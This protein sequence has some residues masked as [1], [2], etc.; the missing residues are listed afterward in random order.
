MNTIL[1]PID[2]HSER[3]A[4]RNLH[5]ILYF[6]KLRLNIDRFN[7]Y[8]SDNNF[9]RSYTKE[10][11]SQ[12]FAAAT[13]KLV[14]QLEEILKLKKS[15]ANSVN[16]LTA[17]KL[18]ELLIEF[19]GLD[20]DIPEGYPFKIKDDMKSEKNY[21]I[22][23]KVMLV[24]DKSG[25]KITVI[26][27]N[28]NLRSETELG[29]IETSASGLFTISYEPVF[30]KSEFKTADIFFR[31][32]DGEK[33]LRD[34]TVLKVTSTGKNVLPDGILFNATASV[35]VEIKLFEQSAPKVLSE[36]EDIG[37]L[38]IPL[39]EDTAIVA[40]NENDEYRDFS[41]LSRETELD[42]NKIIR[43][44]LSYRLLAQSGID[45]EFW[46]AL[47]SGSFYQDVTKSLTDQNLDTN[48]PKT[49][50]ALFTV[51]LTSV[52]ETVKQAFEAT[53]IS[54]ELESR[55][56]KWVKQFSGFI[57]KRIVNMKRE[58]H[59]P[60]VKSLM[61]SAGLTKEK[62][63]KFLSI[64]LNH[65]GFDEAF[66]KQVEK[67]KG[68][69]ENET[70]KL[71][72]AHS[73][74]KLEGNNERLVSLAAALPR[75]TSM[76]ELALKHNTDSLSKLLT[77]E[78]LPDD[79]EGKT[80]KSKIK[81]YASTIQRQLFATE[82]S[83]V[84]QRMATNKELP[85]KDDQISKG[86]ADFFDNQSEFN[87][88]TT[89]IYNAIKSENAFKGIAEKHREEVVSHLKT[90][91]RV[92][93]ISPANETVV[94][95]MKANISTSHRVTEMSESSFMTAF[96]KKMGEGVA[97]QVYTNA[98]NLKLRNE[99]ALISMKEHVEG[100]GISLIDGNGTMD[101]RKVAFDT[102]AAEN[103]I[104]LNWETLFGNVDLCECG[105]CTSVYSPAAYFV[106]LLQYLRN[107]DLD[108][109]ATGVQAIKPDPKDISDTVL[110]KLFRRRPDLGCLE[111]TC[112][113]T[114]TI[115]PY[116]DLVNEVMESFIVHLAG[117][118]KSKLNPKQATIDAWNVE[119]E[120]T[121]ELLAQPQ[122]IN[123][124]AYLELKKAVYPFTL[125]Y[126]RPVDMIRIFLRYLDTS[127]YELMKTFRA[128]EQNVISKD[129][130]PED[131]KLPV[132]PSPD[133]DE[134]KI[135][136]FNK[137]LSDRA[138]D[139]EFLS[140]TQ[141]EYIILTKEAYLTKDYFNL[142]SPGITEGQYKAQIGVKDVPEYYG[143]TGSNGKS[144]MLSTDETLQ[145]GLTFVK[146][147]FL[148][149]TGL[150]YID[151]VELLKTEALN[152]MYPKG[153]AML[154]LESIPFSYRFLQGLED[155]TSLDPPIR[156]KKLIDALENPQNYIL[157]YDEMNDFNPCKPQ[158]RTRPAFKSANI[159]QWVFCYFERI[160]KMI[161][162]ENN[163]PD[164]DCVEGQFFR[165]DGSD[166][167][168][169]V[170][171]EGQ[172]FLT[173]DCDLVLKR[174]DFQ[175]TVGHID[176][177]SGF[178]SLKD[179]NGDPVK[180]SVLT[181][182][183]VIFKGNNGEIGVIT[184]ERLINRRT[185][186]P[187]SC[188]QQ[189]TDTCDLNLVR[190]KHLDGT[191]LSVN[192]YDKM[193]R[194]IRL[195]R[196]M[197]WSIDETDKSLVALTADKTTYT[198]G[199][200]DACDPE[201]DPNGFAE[202]TP[203]FIHQLV[204]I[205]KLLDSTGLELIKLLAFWTTISTV[206]EKSLYK[207]LF[208]THN[209]LAIDDIFKADTNGNFLSGTQKIVDHIPV[210]MAAFHLKYE[211]IDALVSA[212]DLLTIQSVSMLYRN[213]VLAKLLH[214]KTADIK[215]IIALF[216]ADPFQ[217]ADKALEFFEKWDKMESSGFTFT[218]L[219]YLINDSDNLL[220]PIKPS[221]NTIIRLAKTI[222]D[223][224]I[225]IDNAHPDLAL[226]D[227]LTIKL[228]KGLTGTERK[229]FLK[230]IATEELVRSKVSL[231]FDQ[232]S[233]ESVMGLLQ[234]T[235]VYSAAVPIP[236][237]PIKT[238]DEFNK[239][240]PNT[241]AAEKKATAFLLKK[242]KYDFTN[243]NVQV[244]G[245]LT[246]KEQ[247]ICKSL[248]PNPGWEAAFDIIRDQAVYIFDDLLA[249]IFVKDIA[250]ATAILLDGDVKDPN[251]ADKDTAPAKREYFL[252]KFLPYL[253][254]KLTE[255][256]LIDTLSG[257]TGLDSSA[258]DILMRDILEGISTKKIMEIFKDAKMPPTS[259]KGWKGYLIP[260]AEESYELAVNEKTTAP[261]FSLQIDGVIKVDENTVPFFSSGP[262]KLKAGQFYLFEVA[263]LTSDLID[264]SWRT[265]ISAKSSLPQQ[266]L[267]PMSAIDVVEEG[268]IKLF[269]AA[270][271][272]NNFS[273]TADEISWLQNHTLDFDKLDFNTLILQHMLRL[274][275]YM[276][277]RDWLP[278]SDIT[279][280]DFFAWT[281]TAA[282]STIPSEKIGLLTGR[283]KEDIDVLIDPLHF[284]IIT[285]KDFSS[286]INLVKLLDA[287]FVYDKID[288]KLDL[289]FEWAKPVSQFNVC[290]LI[291]ETI[292]KSIQARYKQDD[293]EHIVKPLNDQLREHQKQALI[294]YLL[295]QTDLIVWGVVD[296]D[297]LFEFFLI[298]VQMDACMQTSRLKQAISSVQLFVQ[299]CFLGE[300]AIRGI[301]NK[302][303]DRDRWRWMQRNPL[304]V[305][306]KKIYIWPENWTLTSLRDDK[307]AFFKGLESDLLQ[308]D[309]N[310]QNVIDACKT[311]LYKVDEV[312]NMEVIGLH[313]EM[314]VDVNGKETK[315]PL[316]LHV[317]ARTRNAPYFF[318]YRYFHM[319]EANWYAWEKIQ[320]DIPSYD[321]D[322]VALTIQVNLAYFSKDSHMVTF[323]GLINYYPPEFN[324]FKSA[325]GVDPSINLTNLSKDENDKYIFWDVEFPIDEMNGMAVGRITEIEIYGDSFKGT[326]EGK[327]IRKDNTNGC[328][329]VPTVWHGRLL[330]FFPQIMKKTKPADVK[331]VS[332]TKNGA[333]NTEVPVLKPIEYYDIK[334]CWT[335]YRNR[336]W[337][338]KQMSKESLPTH[339]IDGLKQIEYFKFF[340]IV[341]GTGIF[342]IVDD[343]LDLDAGYHGAFT[344]D[345]NT[346]KLGGGGDIDNM[347]INYFN[348]IEPF[349][350]EVGSKIFSWQISDSKRANTSI[351][352][353]NT[354]AKEMVRGVAPASNFYHPYTHDYLSK[355]NLGQID[356]LFDYNLSIPDK[357]D[358][359]GANGVKNYHELKRPYSL[360]NWEL[361][362]HIPVSI[363]RE[364][365]AT[366]QFE[367]AM[368]YYHYVFDPTAKGTDP[369]RFWQFLPFKEVNTD[370]FLVNFFNGLQPNAPVKEINEWRSNPFQPHLIARSRPSTYMKWVVMEYIDNLIA[371][372]DYLFKQDTI[373][374][375]NYATQLYILAAHI[376][377]SFQTIPK[378]GKIKPETY[379]SLLDKWDAFG[380]AMVELELVAP[381][382][383]QISLPVAMVGSN[384]KLATANIFGFA[385]SLYFCIPNNPKLKAYRDT[386]A[387]RLYKIRHCE[388]IEGVFRMLPLWDPPIDPALLVAATAQG[389]SLDSVLN[390]LNTPI[391]NYRF[392]YL[393]QKAID[394]CNEVKSLGNSLLSVLEK[395]DGEALAVMRA[396]HET[397][398]HN[399]VMEVKK[400]QVEEA[401]AALEGLEQNRRTTEYK[402][403]HYLQ[404]IG[405]DV[406][407]VPSEDGSFS[408]ISNQLPTPI[409]EG[410][411][412]LIKEEK[413]EMD[414]AAQA[415]GWQIGSL[416]MDALSSLMHLLPDTTLSIMP[417]GIGIQF[418]HGG[419]NLG[420]AASGMA[421]VLQ[422]ISSIYSY[423]STS[424]QRKAGFRR[425]LQDRILQANLAG[426]ECKQIDKQILS[427]RIRINISNQE[428]TNQQ[429]MIDNT[430]EVEEFL[431]SKYTN[432]ELY[433]WMEGQVKT[434]YR[435][436]YNL[437]YDL[438]KKAELVFRFDRGLASSNF[439]QYGYWDVS[440][441]G[442]LAGEKLF[443]G[444]KQ[445][446]AAYH[447]NRG[448]DF[449]VT[450]HISLQQLNPLAL[451]ELRENGK[452]EFEI[453]EVLFDMDFSGHYMRR[454]KSVA[455]SI[456]CI[457]GPYTS[458]NATLR[459]QEHNYR[460]SP[461]ATNAKDYP[462]KTDENDDRFTT[463]HI[464]IASIATSSGQND[465]GVFELNF[466]DERYM[467]FEGAGVISKWRL[468]LQDKFRQFKYETISDIIIIIRYTSKDGGDKLKKPASDALIKYIESVKELSQREGLFAMFDLKHDFANEWYKA[469]EQPVGI[470]GRVMQLGNLLHRLPVFTQTFNQSKI[471]AKDIYIATSS[472]VK[473]S[474][475]TLNNKNA[476]LGA[477]GEKLK[478]NDTTYVFHLSDQDVTMENWSLKFTDTIAKPDKMWLIVRYTL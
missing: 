41:F 267:L 190:L 207:R 288:L 73:L 122:H 2:Q 392:I 285:P 154:I 261:S 15:Q 381:F 287:L 406:N 397:A 387:D 336:E 77:P 396:G 23:G 246:T 295:V 76:R 102:K 28:K 133:P 452:C 366:Q 69:G 248:F 144:D 256:F 174:R 183:E 361:F 217:N 446:E 294:N 172:L 152:P 7:Q 29:R 272:V 293:W 42:K 136:A 21:T 475:L 65:G 291:A 191:D 34:F 453:P 391:P 350:K 326:F 435:Q 353:E 447:E 163:A 379:N 403:R 454:I 193:H 371:W 473:N 51:T 197:G 411:L 441:N 324:S 344:F 146:K 26:A 289:L 394:L 460:L 316:K 64:Y 292:R 251:V 269:K 180:V 279:L 239:K 115:L 358:A 33:E 30:R 360:Y 87:I 58:E 82:T 97:R 5:Y 162:L 305:A 135:P 48:F 121:G 253:R 431:K 43:F 352:F 299:R 257:A 462:R 13:S 22:T 70:K 252:E 169:I 108:P 347:P 345:G 309:I 62:Q 341:T 296:A 382:S 63:E 142:R 79:V 301:P 229:D 388:N 185:D 232:K 106:E 92:Q 355:I 39:L 236:A 116:V 230:K 221:K 148:K 427:Q 168:E 74:T 418:E 443:L 132:S 349:F 224:L 213:A 159:K 14:M 430:A 372:G 119:D 410:G 265:A 359:F 339:P 258:A 71:Q 171:T 100:T 277:L 38:I 346:I 49:I 419:T 130:M 140:I 215:E 99:Q 369:K 399:L 340:P 313:I 414:K 429:K 415:L 109:N 378:R 50:K 113:N 237:T 450:K 466:K 310:K 17:S 337:T 173:K 179:K 68:L 448:H 351:Y 60:Y 194:F 249:D 262:L 416:G 44:A 52:N 314:E 334:M 417:L 134:D 356:E 434:L 181:N 472:S 273:L 88:R 260:A 458:V 245:I 107:N 274:E 27:F 16:E 161:V 383:N 297:S 90:L 46:Y 104:P 390:D 320:V 238:V 212:S 120:T 312:T 307:S 442:L 218:Q 24:N 220:K 440:R 1:T 141:E 322:D 96:S 432:E 10:V 201:V 111:L 91:Q 20:I 263:G 143:Y 278:D 177:M 56:P 325:F 323:N 114:N 9:F 214:V 375:V 321:V 223:G 424:A 474:D 377:P 110:E 127:R 385:S 433:K 206:G 147:Q 12:Q 376:V 374:T 308:K 477:F 158:D 342:I 53:L 364:L 37:R 149:R 266:V 198:R 72:F 199:F 413:E 94:M 428:I 469:M 80:T 47:T 283:K 330:V 243:N 380:N 409:D 444:L 436:V 343:N 302:I 78:M 210:L 125:P 228:I 470:T 86:V 45:A 176:S 36:F 405:E 459:L 303:L 426:Y 160:G 467:P 242:I 205:K 367:E 241:T 196:K 300:E 338:Q 445:L 25:K 200:E 401:N 145:I 233:A 395:K 354:A 468:E 112:A 271:V 186:R 476:P 81:N 40:L 31:L 254:K 311:Y 18:N 451:L 422:A 333:G 264:I 139:A 331:K 67:E 8:F 57:T 182:Q 298:D 327:L 319:K 156:F 61:S 192:E 138:L 471:K 137:I 389:L 98:T 6:L 421:K 59:P 84:L 465:S 95:L 464:P 195:R 250:G 368:K 370:N 225:G 175:A 384:G 398:M 164:C 75:I 455:L 235:I 208:L 187:F 83:A 449:E 54:S 329:L 166:Y 284:N 318:Y 178:V 280:V 11:E 189:N 117:Y 202:I 244:T 165:R 203:D 131:T 270:F 247:T 478:I 188:K 281:Y 167:I 123:D 438:A 93:A 153:K 227:E 129:V 408:E 461:I 357:D 184:L 105:E 151:L 386:I 348:K 3:T 240:F 457:A 456:P 89:S 66:W 407:R 286:E 231:L 276:R 365:S 259:P 170:D 275:A 363:A 101:D 268:F 335:E 402:L 126:D 118:T 332:T 304:W 282:A 103:N 437:A 306:N 209:L 439:I 157:G 211:E 404:L 85:I 290:L 35:E 150:V 362:F 463:A 315:E 204:A 4:V 255:K 32:Y 425:Q 317:F 226:L 234:G 219:N 373:E 328:F 423:E 216:T 128:V 124:N 19:G 55:L 155:K 400:M 222:Y 420:Y 393:L 412:K